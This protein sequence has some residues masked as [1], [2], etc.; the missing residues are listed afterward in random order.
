M[1]P[2]KEW[3]SIMCVELERHEHDGVLRWRAVCSIPGREGTCTR[4]WTGS[5]GRLSE[6]TYL[7]LTT[8]IEKM[9]G[10]AITI[11]D[12]GIQLQ[13]AMIERSVT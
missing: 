11:R 6:G 2:K 1:P 13:L 10:D 8:A 7:D 12:S 3:S 4:S 5:G 9:V